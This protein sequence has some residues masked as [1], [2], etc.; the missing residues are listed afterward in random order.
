MTISPQYSQSFMFSASFTPMLDAHSMWRTSDSI[1]WHSWQ[2]GFVV[3]HPL[4]GDT[5]LLGKAAAHILVALQ[6]STAD[7]RSLSL[8]L[9]DMMEVSTSTEF[10][11]Q[12]NQIL[13]DLD[14]LALIERR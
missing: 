7:T 6:Q 3:Y 9:A 11:K 5:H 2:D 8:S 1:H 14:T 10:M 13:T 12:M 4:T